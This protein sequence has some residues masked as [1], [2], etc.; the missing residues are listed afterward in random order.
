MEHQDILLDKN[1][2]QS[3]VKSKSCFATG[4][5]VYISSWI[6]LVLSFL[7]EYLQL[8]IQNN[9]FQSYDYS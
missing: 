1:S 7:V 8:F 4:L 9:Y 5:L 2:G 6:L 3:S